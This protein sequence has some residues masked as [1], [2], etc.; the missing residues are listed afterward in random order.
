MPVSACS[1]LPMRV[2]AA[3]VNAPALVPEEL[4]L[5]ELGRQR[6]AVHLDER[7]VAPRRSLVDRARDQLLADAALAANQHGDVAV[8]DLLDHR[9]DAAHLLAVA[10]HRPVFV[11]GQLLAQLAQLGDEPVLLDRVLDRDV[12]RDFA[13]AL[14]VVGLDDVVGRAEAHGLDNR[15]R[16]V[17]ARKHD[18]LR[19]RPGG[20]ERPERREPIQAGHHH[21]EQDDVGRLGLLHRGEQLVAARV[22]ARFIAAQGKER[23][24]VGGE[25]GIV[26]DNGDVGLLHLSLCKGFRLFDAR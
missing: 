1:N 5:E 17:P 24:Q 16:L 2:V 13:E 8:G 15:G 23:P 11:V 6:G 22:A 7:P 18:D 3:P 26:V 12:E 19:F 10:P 9:R 4:A 14:R 20:L 21:V 25:G